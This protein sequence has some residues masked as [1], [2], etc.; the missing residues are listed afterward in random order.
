MAGRQNA[1][2][3]WA[4]S[5][6]SFFVLTSSGDRRTLPPVEQAVA[7]RVLARQHVRERWLIE[8]FHQRANLLGAHRRSAQDAELEHGADQDRPQLLVEKHVTAPRAHGAQ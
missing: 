7:A 6:G 1:A 4:T 3:G 5:P 8:L 2:R